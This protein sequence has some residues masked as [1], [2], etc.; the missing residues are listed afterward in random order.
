MDGYKINQTITIDVKVLMAI[1]GVQN[2]EAR[3]I[4]YIS[5]ATNNH[6]IY[7]CYK[8]K[9]KE[10]RANTY[11]ERKVNPMIKVMLVFMFLMQI[12]LTVRHLLLLLDKGS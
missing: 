11:R 10:K 7:K 6:F 4:N 12:I 1:K 5:I 3:E 2:L 8:L 9:N